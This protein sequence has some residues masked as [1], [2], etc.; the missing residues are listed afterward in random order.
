LS[1]A[2][3]PIMLSVIMLKI[4]IMLNVMVPTLTLSPVLLK[5]N[6]KLK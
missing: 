3:K 2:F 1:I 4:V 5:T 6:N